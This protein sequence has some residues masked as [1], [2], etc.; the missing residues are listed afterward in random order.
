[1][2]SP[3]HGGIPLALP[4][5]V[6]GTA[7]RSTREGESAR[8][9]LVHEAIDRG[10]TA[11]DTAPLYELGRVEAELGRALRGRRDEVLLL[12][13]VG[14]RW[15][16]DHGEALFESTVDG[17]R[18]VVRRDGRPE[19]VR[20]DVEESLQRL[21]TDVL[22]LVQV[23]QPDHRTPVA[24]TVGELA[25]LRDE[26]KLRFIGLSNHPASMLREAVDAL[27]SEG[28]ST[29][30]EHYSLLARGIEQGLLPAA[31][32]R[33]IGVLA[34]SALEAGILADRTLGRGRPPT[35]RGPLFHPRNV[36]RIQG[37]LRGVVLPL[38]REKGVGLAEIC[39]AWVLHQPGVESVIIGASS[40]EQ[41][42]ANERA[43]RLDLSPEEAARLCDAFESIPI[44]W[45]AGRSWSDRARGLFRRRVRAVRRG[46][47][48]ARLRR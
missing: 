5:I 30:Q 7:W 36:D 43:A 42:E 34:Y 4:R 6:L 25:R 22:D 21:A 40:P 12:T 11:I 26:G 19:A 37:A 20:R 1:M 32:E 48:R 44:D 27:G 28:V 31:R 13:K 41:L 38:A 8:T 23:H 39:L 45:T 10:L 47:A 29:C 33:G 18:R 16:S 3:A 24:E 9:R 17:Q 35:D 14:L 46:W 2:E 15:D